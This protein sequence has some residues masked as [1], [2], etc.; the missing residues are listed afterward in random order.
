MQY[1]SCS[2]V[3]CH[4]KASRGSSSSL[5]LAPL[6]CNQHENGRHL[7]SYHHITYGS[8]A[9][10][11]TTWK[12]YFIR[13]LLGKYTTSTRLAESVF[14]IQIIPQSRIQSRISHQEVPSVAI[15][16]E[17]TEY[18]AKF[19]NKDIC[20]CCHRIYLITAEFQPCSVRTS[21]LKQSYHLLR[22]LHHYCTVFR[23]GLRYL[24]NLW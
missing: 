18:S 5:P 7:L 3:L 13:P 16:E 23:F 14:R 8:L 12:S 4:N 24:A 17:K 20:H 19:H 2:V 10:R 21:S 11:L 6:Q 1:T 15:R 9:E 22:S